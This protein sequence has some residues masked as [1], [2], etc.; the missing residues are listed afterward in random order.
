METVTDPLLTPEQRI[1]D[2]VM[3]AAKGGGCVIVVA[4][5]KVHP[6]ASVM[7]TE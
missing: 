2:G 3:D 6:W 7:V 4:A 1:L 5:E